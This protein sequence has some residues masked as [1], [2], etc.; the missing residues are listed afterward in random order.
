MI[1]VLL[2]DDHP[3]ER[4]GLHLALE[5][6]PDVRVIA[7]FNGIRE[8]MTSLLPPSRADVVICDVRLGDGS[9]FELLAGAKRLAN[10]P[11]FLFFSTSGA[12]TYLEAAWRLGAAG[13]VLKTASSD[14]VVSA[15]RSIAAGGYAFDAQFEPGATV[16]RPLTTRE[17]QVVT[18]VIAG[19]SNGEIA[20]G[21]GI[22]TK[23]VE[24]HLSKL[25]ARTGAISRTELAVKAERDHWLD[26]PH[27]AENEGRRSRSSI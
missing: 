2:V 22:S 1:G 18:G 7:A 9:G 26:V 27:A 24:A 23:T 6:V 14:K 4:D 15:V 20:G 19:L 11:G 12:P 17:F 13:F 25:F 3:A 8:A 21:I 10:P 16:W 5:S